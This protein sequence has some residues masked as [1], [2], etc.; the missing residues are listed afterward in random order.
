MDRRSF[1]QGV[2]SRC[3]A[4][5][6]PFAQYLSQMCIKITGRAASHGRSDGE[7]SECK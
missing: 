1:R 7:D 6:I 2:Q 5:C 4:I 3:E